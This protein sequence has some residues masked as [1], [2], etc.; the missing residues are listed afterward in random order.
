[1][2]GAAVARADKHRRSVLLAGASGLVG[3]ELLPI[4][5]LIEIYIEAIDGFAIKRI[6]INA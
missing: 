2:S 1:M 3:R 5:R 6:G 4:G